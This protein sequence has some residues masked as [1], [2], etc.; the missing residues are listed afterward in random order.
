[1]TAGTDRKVFLWDLSDS[2]DKVRSELVFRC[3]T[4]IGKVIRVLRSARDG[5]MLGM[6][7]ESSCSK[8]AAPYLRYF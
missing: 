2:D 1:M 7:H 6:I 8:Y 5:Q 4:G 3:H